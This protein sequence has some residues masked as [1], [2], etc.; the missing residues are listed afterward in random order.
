MTTTDRRQSAGWLVVTDAETRAATAEETTTARTARTLGTAQRRALLTAADHPLGYFPEAVNYRTLCALEERDLAGLAGRTGILAGYRIRDL[1]K[2]RCSITTAGRALAAEL[3]RERVII[4]PCGGAKLDDVAPAG[5]MYTGTYHRAARRAAEQLAGPGGRVIILSAKYG[6]LPLDQWIRPYDLKAGD[7]GTVTPATLRHQA[8]ALLLGGAEVTVLG[9]SAYVAL[10]RSVWPHAAAPLHGT[11]GIGEQMQRLASIAVGRQTDQADAQQA[12]EPAAPGTET[13]AELPFDVKVSEDTAEAAA[14]NLPAQWANPY[15][16]RRGEAAVRLVNGFTA[17][18][19]NAGA[20]LEF[21]DTSRRGPERRELAA[22]LGL[23]FGVHFEKIVNFRTVYVDTGH[24]ITPSGH[25]RGTSERR[26]IRESRLGR[27][28]TDARASAAP[29]DL[30]RFCAVLPIVLDE[31]DRL[32][33]IWGRRCAAWLTGEGEHWCTPAERRTAVRHFRRE[34]SAALAHALAMPAQ[35]GTEEDLD[36]GKPYPHQARAAARAALRELGDDWLDRVTRPGTEAAYRL[37][38]TTAEQLA[39]GVADRHAAEHARAARQRLETE[40]AERRAAEQQ[41]AAELD[42]DRVELT[43]EQLAE[44]DRVLH[45]QDY[46]ADDEP[47]YVEAPITATGAPVQLEPEPDAAELRER[48]ELLRG[49]GAHVAAEAL[50]D[51]AAEL[52]AEQHQEE[53]AAVEDLLADVGGRPHRAPHRGPRRVTGPQGN[54]SRRR[55]QTMPAASRL[56]PPTASGGRN[57][58]SPVRGTGGAL[59][60]PRKPTREA[61]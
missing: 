29:A 18:R 42:A 37:A 39:A 33:G 51:R 13:A 30:A 36:P 15:T 46:P 2:S 40:L 43:A 55:P 28:R 8:F 25:W 35:A 47:G 4:V 58:R 48:A 17:Y 9:G 24:E 61:S 23:Y 11:R 31:L 60:A 12:P 32:S 38:A 5:E 7:P 49:I 6:L 16:P 52:D 22:T 50:L 19:N 57:R 10:A 1:V 26:E 54:R 41:R 27:G 59:H 14:Y 44:L 3:P 53:P 21:A 45:P 34:F 56:R 20:R